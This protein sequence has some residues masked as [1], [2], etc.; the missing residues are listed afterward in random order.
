MLGQGLLGPQPVLLLST[1]NVHALAY[2]LLE[3]P[4]RQPQLHEK[5]HSDAHYVGDLSGLHSA[6]AHAIA[7]PVYAGPGT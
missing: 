4:L 1:S 5:L 6:N 3:H 7:C 2:G